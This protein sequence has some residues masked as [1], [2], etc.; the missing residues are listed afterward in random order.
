MRWP[1]GE[2]EPPAAGGAGGSARCGRPRSGRC[3]AAA[4]SWPAAD[5]RFSAEL[6][7]RPT[8]LPTAL[9]L[10][11]EI[12]APEIQTS[13]KSRNLEVEGRIAWRVQVQQ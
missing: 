5:T 2:D 7:A 11:C 13:R 1:G 9:Q 8:R 12:W 3:A 10:I 4:D 6:Q